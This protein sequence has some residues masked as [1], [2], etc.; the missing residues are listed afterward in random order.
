MV[1]QKDAKDLGPQGRAIKFT[2]GAFLPPGFL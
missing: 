2:L 1:E